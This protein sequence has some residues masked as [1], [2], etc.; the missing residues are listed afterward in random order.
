VLGADSAVQPTHLLGPALEHCWKHG[1][2]LSP[3][4]ILCLS[5]H[6]ILNL[7]S[8]LLSGSQWLQQRISPEADTN[9]SKRITHNIQVEPRITPFLNWHPS[10]EFPLVH[11]CPGVAL[12]VNQQAVAEFFLHEHV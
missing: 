8:H 6:C 7:K 3:E 4:K 9:E 11:Q 5:I 2:L 12:F 1:F 10:A